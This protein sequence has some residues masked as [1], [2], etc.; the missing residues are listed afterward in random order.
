MGNDHSLNRLTQVLN[1]IEGNLSAP[2]DLNTLAEVSHWSRWQLQRVFQKHTGL[3]VA[4]YIRQLRLSQSASHL[5][6]SSSRQIDIAM[7]A[8]F[9]SEISFSRAFRQFF[10][11]SPREYRK[12]GEIIGIRFPLSNTA[13]H[14]IRL[15]YK[16]AFTFYGIYKDVKGI[17]FMQ[18][19]IKK[20]APIVWNNAKSLLEDY[21]GSYNPLQ[22]VLNVGRSQNR[23]IQYWVGSDSFSQ[24]PPKEFSTLEVPAQLYAVV[25]HRGSLKELTN[26]ISWFVAHWL[27]HSPYR[28]YPSFDIEQYIEFN[29]ETDD[30]HI[31]YWVPVKSVENQAVDM[32]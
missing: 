1:Y 6:G 21:S 17:F 26:T 11:C 25:T 19:N 9:D 31:D 14:S 4:Q 10:G 2:L 3:S 12:R 24:Q 32:Q 18:S 22:A 20:S 7:N 23:Y 27:L 13:M 5:I 15:E 29:E 16:A 30:Y 28:A 8:G